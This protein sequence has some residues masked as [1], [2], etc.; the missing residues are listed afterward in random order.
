MRHLLDSLTPELMPVPG[1]RIGEGLAAAHELLRNGAA[2][3]GEVIKLLKDSQT[4]VQKLLKSN[5]S[6]LHTIAKALMEKETL[7]GNEIRAL[8]GMPPAKEPVAVVSRAK[9]KAPKPKAPEAKAEKPS[10]DAAEE[11]ETTIIV[12]QLKDEDD[13]PK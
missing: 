11:D 5:L 2:V 1:G 8:I 6:D 10:E 4:R 13:S 9:P 3:D 12:I 7:T